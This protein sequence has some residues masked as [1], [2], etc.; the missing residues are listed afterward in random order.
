MKLEVN[1]PEGKYCEGCI[2]A[3]KYDPA[4]CNFVLA[5]EDFEGELAEDPDYSY[6]Y[7]KHP[8]CPSLKDVE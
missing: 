6:S 7:I 3:S 2:F 8:H 4:T 1:I 5:H